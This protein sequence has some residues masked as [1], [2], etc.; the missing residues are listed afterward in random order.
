MAEYQKVVI[1]QFNQENHLRKVTPRNRPDL[2]GEIAGAAFWH[3]PG[4]DKNKKHIPP[5][6]H[7]IKENLFTP[8]EFINNQW[9]ELIWDSTPKFW[10]Y[11]AYYE[12]QIPQGM[13]ELG[14]L[15]NILKAKTPVAVTPLS[16]L[17]VALILCCPFIVSLPYL[18]DR[19]VCFRL[20]DL[21]RILP[22]FRSRFQYTGV[23]LYWGRD[24]DA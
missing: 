15:G 21:S 14:Y 13:Y 4:E 9:Y 3:E 10:G 23:S 1:D 17:G 22:P 12:R 11:W 5:S 7:C 8:I 16:Y 6:Y 20:P 19:T 18:Y 24:L 2:P